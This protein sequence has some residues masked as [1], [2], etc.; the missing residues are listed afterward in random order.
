M[1]STRRLLHNE[2]E[3][4]PGLAESMAGSALFCVYTLL[5]HPPPRQKDI[6]FTNNKLI[7]N[8]NE[9]KTTQFNESAPRRSIAGRGSECLGV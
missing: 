9:N 6:Y 8:N 5:S 1:R 4:V 3:A 2:F 7:I